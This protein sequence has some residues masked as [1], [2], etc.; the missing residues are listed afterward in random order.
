MSAT[1]DA[2]TPAPS[3]EQTGLVYAWAAA[4][5]AAGD[6]CQCWKD[7]LTW[8][9]LVASVIA[10]AAAASWLGLNLYRGV[11]A[12][13]VAAVQAAAALPPPPAPAPPAAPLPPPAPASLKPGPAAA[14]ETPPPEAAPKPAPSA[15]P[16][17]PYDTPDDA[18][19]LGTELCSELDEWGGREQ[20]L[21]NIMGPP[22]GLTRAQADEQVDAAIR[23]YCPRN[24]GK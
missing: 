18:V 6:P 22:G 7:R 15:P 1:E 13:Q 14:H 24:A 20:V 17:M 16:L 8:A 19:A 9:V 10:T 11:H 2:T 4:D 21:R 12:P 23:G 3:E 5:D